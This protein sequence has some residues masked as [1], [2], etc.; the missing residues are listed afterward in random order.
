METLKTAVVV[1]LLLAVL[2]GAYVVLNK[3]EAQMP[4]DV[5]AFDQNLAGPP[6][7]D[8]GAAVGG[9]GAP[10]GLLKVPSL[11]A[12]SFIPVHS[13]CFFAT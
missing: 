12:R 13:R 7:I 3:P 5:A 2:Y 4:D 8:M 11:K 6:Q 10:A 1:V 9:Y